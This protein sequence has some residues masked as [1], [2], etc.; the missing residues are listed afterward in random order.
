MAAGDRSV[1]DPSEF[2]RVA[3]VETGEQEDATEFSTLL[4]DWLERELGKGQEAQG[5]GGGFISELFQGEV[6]H[7]LTCF[8]DPSHRFERR[9][10]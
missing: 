2:V 9:E 6:S 7:L 1:V 10:P 8:A 4:L 3:G 5:G